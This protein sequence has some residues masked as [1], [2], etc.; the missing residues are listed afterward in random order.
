MLLSLLTLHSW[1]DLIDSHLLTSALAFAA[2]VSFGGH[3][4]IY[5]DFMPRI[6]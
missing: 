5:F 4:A 1:L 2:L 3:S 6:S